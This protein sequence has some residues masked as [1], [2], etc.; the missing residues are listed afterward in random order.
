[1]MAR[2][3]HLRKYNLLVLGEVGVG[4]STLTIHFTQGYFVNEY[5]PVIED[6][7]RRTCVLNDECISLK[8]QDTA[9]QEDGGM[10][11][12]NEGY[13]TLAHGFLL[14][15]SITSHESFKVLDFYWECIQRLKPGAPLLL[16]GNKSDL[17]PA[18]RE[19]GEDEGRARAAQFRGS[20]RE[21]SAKERDQVEEAFM[22]LVREI[23]E[24]DKDAEGGR[25][26]NLDEHATHNWRC[27]G[28]VV[29]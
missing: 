24:R 15:Y 1:M 6:S 2:P 28:C 16:I 14:V 5:D 17:A 21:T 11:P 26:E 7:F 9:W 18:A 12:L 8:I 19:V 25:D 22:C 23:R 4:K 27:S 10:P 3:Q 20:F 13:Y 29:L